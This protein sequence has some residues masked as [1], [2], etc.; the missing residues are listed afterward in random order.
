MDD[1]ESALNME[2]DK[3]DK[4]KRMGRT[5]PEDKVITMAA[6]SIILIAF[7]GVIVSLLQ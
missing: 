5:S 1:L 6:S 2:W 7:L 3:M 4:Y